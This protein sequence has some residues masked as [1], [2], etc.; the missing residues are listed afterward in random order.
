M[1]ARRESAPAG[2][3][4]ALMICGLATM[5]LLASAPLLADDASSAVKGFDAAWAGI[6]TYTC[7][8]EEHITNG[9][10]HEDR[11]YR[12]WFKKPMNLRNEITQGNRGGDR[13]SVAVYRGGDRVVG[14]QGGMLSMINLSLPL[15]DPKTTSIRG[16]KI[17]DL[18]WSHQLDVLHGFEAHG[19][20]EAGTP[21]TFEG[22]SVIPLTMSSSD[23]AWV[24][25]SNQHY[26]RQNLDLAARTHVPVLLECFEQGTP[27]PVVRLI[28]R[29][30]Q[31]NVTIPDK[32][33]DSHSRM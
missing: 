2:R 4:P 3:A 15:D 29:K 23:S 6:N 1:M 20:V 8:I 16:G 5:A 11:I 25:G 31:L 27:A 19:K 13:G 14:H 33:W 21:T 22:V 10:S 24:N 26:W 9:S 12:F 18:T 7:E 30:A 28:W 17:T 32:A